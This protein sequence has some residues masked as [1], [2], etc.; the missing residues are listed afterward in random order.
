MISFP[1]DYLRNEKRT[2]MLPITQKFFLKYPYGKFYLIPDM[3]L[4]LRVEHVTIVVMQ[5]M[6][7]C[8]ILMET[9]F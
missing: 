3:L 8:L 7:F 1:E 2:F 9:L 4:I 5:L 6:S